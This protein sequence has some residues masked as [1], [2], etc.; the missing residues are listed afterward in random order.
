MGVARDCTAKT[1]Q[2]DFYFETT[3]ISLRPIKYKTNDKAKANQ[4]RVSK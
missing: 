2:L 1:K 4:V 3:M